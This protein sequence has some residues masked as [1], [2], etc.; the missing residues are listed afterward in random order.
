MRNLVC[1]LVL[2]FFV[3]GCATTKSDF[4]VKSDDSSKSAHVVGKVT[5]LDNGKP[6]SPNWSDPCKLYINGLSKSDAYKLDQSGEF[7]M[8]VKPGAF[9]IRK[10]EC[11]S[12]LSES[13]FVFYPVIPSSVLEPNSV[14]YI[15]DITVNWELGGTKFDWSSLLTIGDNGF[16]RYGPIDLVVEKSD[17]TK[18]SFFSQFPK[19]KA[20]SYVERPIQLIDVQKN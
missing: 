11:H 3:S 16:H 7:F 2:V 8:S 12:G 13:T 20:M 14:N 17:K 1:L 5:V 15:G 4:T 18:N 10:I 9:T 6:R 19:A